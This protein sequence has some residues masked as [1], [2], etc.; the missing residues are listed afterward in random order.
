MAFNKKL[1]EIFKDWYGVSL[2]EVSEKPE[3]LDHIRESEKD[4]KKLFDNHRK[5]DNIKSIEDYDRETQRIL[6]LL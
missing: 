4:F 1:D 2:D 3:L 6:N 5:N